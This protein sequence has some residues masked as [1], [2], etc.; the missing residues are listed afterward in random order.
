M[1]HECAQCF[2]GA[3]Q[4]GGI[5]YGGDNEQP[6]RGDDQ[7]YPYGSCKDEPAPMQPG[8]SFIMPLLVHRGLSCCML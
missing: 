4:S 8:V 3:D 2:V 1:Q 5:E 6:E 7:G